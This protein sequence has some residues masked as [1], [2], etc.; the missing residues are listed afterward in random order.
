VSSNSAL[1]REIHEARPWKSTRPMHGN[2][3]Y[4]VRPLPFTTVP[5]TA[6]GPEEEGLVCG[7]GSVQLLE[8][9]GVPRDPRGIVLA[10][11]FF[12]AGALGIG[13]LLL[14]DP[15]GY[16]FLAA[17][18]VGY[19]F[20]QTR[21]LPTMLWLSIAAYGTVGAL[22]GEPI[23]W[24]ECGLGLLLA[25]IALVP[26]PAIYRIQPVPAGTPVPVSAPSLELR[27]GETSAFPEVSP[28]R[29]SANVEVGVAAPLQTSAKAEESHGD[30]KADVGPT[31]IDDSRPRLVIRS[32]GQLR[33]TGPGGDLAPELE[34]RPV[35]AF[36]WKYLLA[37]WVSGD[38]QVARTALSDEASPGVSEASQRERLRKQLH[39]LQRHLP[40][41]L[42]ALVRSNRTHAWLDLEGIESDVASLREL[43]SRVRQ[44]G[45]LIDPA[46]SREIHDTL[47]ESDSLEF[48][49]GF[50]ELEQKVN[51]GRGTAGQVV[52]EARMAIANQRAELIRA[53]AE[54]EDAMGR[55][56]AA[57]PHL[58][59]ALDALPER[60]DLARLLVVAYLKTGQTARA[61]EVRRQF[62]LKQE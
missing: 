51:Q 23:N 18:A 32:I 39:D 24:I 21:L 5:N 52:A 12:G 36:L 37:R 15:I 29:S 1:R 62:A 58:V 57:I 38:P 30:R 55:P 59:G 8:T 35:L 47:A 44:R 6:E 3:G 11:G 9:L 33:L 61:S 56:E 46:L 54:Y 42:A 41:E 19:F 2:R 20:L 22:A 14:H 17:A 7:E 16:G 10:C 53:L 27:N 31:V 25:G 50:E 4:T 43:S 26:V 48:L 49:A 45:F 13:A 40:A 28:T 60:Q 34:D